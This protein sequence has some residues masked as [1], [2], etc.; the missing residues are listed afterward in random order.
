[1]STIRD[2]AK[3]AGVSIATVSY[4][5]NDGPRPVNAETRKR[6]LEVMQ[7]ENYVPNPT[8]RRLSKKQTDC[9]GLILAGMT[10]SN[11]SNP[12]YL[13]YIRGISFAAETNGYNLLLFTNHKKEKQATF[14]KEL[15]NSRQ[16]DGLL[17][18]GSSIP[19]NVLSEIASSGFPHVLLARQSQ[20]PNVVCVSQDYQRGTFQLTTFLLERGYRRLGFLG[21][22]QKFSYG[23][24]RLEG[25]QQA[26]QAFN[27]PVDEEL[28]SIPASIRDDPGVEE[29]KKM[30]VLANPPDVLMTDREEIVQA[31]LREL[32]LRIPEQIALAGMD[33]CESAALFET[34]LTTLRSPKFTIGKKSIEMLIKQIKKQ[35]INSPELFQMELIVGQSTPYRF[36]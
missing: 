15:I 30:M 27:L 33:E 8:A 21:Q 14:I 35:S 3:I 31:R 6:I 19:D 23:K 12:F 25:Y 36:N 26:L 9:I 28:I 10:Q 24:A 29:I 16:V 7:A 4:V 18:L 17:M 32:G 11:F 1:M 20:D 22:S 34:P 13:E 2:I 5:I